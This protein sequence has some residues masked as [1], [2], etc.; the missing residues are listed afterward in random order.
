V[1][2]LFADAKRLHVFYRMHAASDD[3]LLATLEAMYLHVRIA[4]GKVVAAAD[5]TIEPLLALA[6]THA[7]LQKPETAGRFVGQRQV[8]D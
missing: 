3:R 1:Q 4:S 8:K 2:I 5:A 6:R 7:A